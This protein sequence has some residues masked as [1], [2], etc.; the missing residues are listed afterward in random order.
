MVRI[1]DSDRRDD[2]GVYRR[3]SNG[4]EPNLGMDEQRGLII[5]RFDLCFFLTG[6]AKSEDDTALISRGFT[7]FPPR[8]MISYS[9]SSFTASGLMYRLPP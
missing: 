1:G 4:R 9:S 7:L 2:N 3:E 8:F 5:N 6:C